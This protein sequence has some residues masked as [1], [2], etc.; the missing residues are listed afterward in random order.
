MDQTVTVDLGDRSY[1]VRIG[2]GLLDGLGR[3]VA[4][5][6]DVSSAVLVSDSIVGDLYAATALKS[7]KAAGLT[8]AYLTFPA[9]EASKSLDVFGDLM[10]QLF[11]VSP[12]IDRKGVIVALGGGVVGDLAGFVAASALRGLRWVQCPTTL[13]ADVDASVGGKTAIDHAA[14]KNLIGA[15]HQPRAV[16]IDVATLGTLPEA[17]LG[18]GLAECVKHGVIR[19]AGLIDFLADGADD[20]L[21]CKPGV[22]TELI[23]RNV[24]IK[25]AVVSADEREAGQ[26]AHLNFG[27]TIGHAIEAA[28]GYE[29]MPHGRAV[30][31]GMV[32]ACGMAVAR[33][34]IGAANAGAVTALLDRLGLPVR[35]A[36]LDADQIWT[37]MQHDKKALG[38]QVRMVLP[39]RLGEVTV[40]DDVTEGEVAGAVAA[41]GE[42]KENA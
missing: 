3:A 10:D 18:N 17:A 36:G 24:A 13:L 37:L 42:P 32:A 7:L 34:M 38:G 2:P 23:T 5:I 14:G 6:G 4:D 1:D 9:G 41:L 35:W 19:D 27:H 21:A 12:A 39:T 28:V 33:K 22:M 16:V 31:L 30:S 15:F 20:I 40:V 11:A 8:V 25:A 29:H 26:R